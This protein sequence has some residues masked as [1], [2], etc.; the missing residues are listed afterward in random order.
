MLTKLSSGTRFSKVPETFR[1][2]KAIFSSSVSENR[3][4]YQYA[5][6]HK[7]RNLAMAL[8]ARKVSEAFEKRSPA[9]VDLTPKQSI[10]VVVFIHKKQFMFF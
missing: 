9:S 10:K 2:H 1:A 5:L 4:V 3:E 6:I 8:R 7:V